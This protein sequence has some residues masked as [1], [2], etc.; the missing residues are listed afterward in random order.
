LPPLPLL[1]PPSLLDSFSVP[2]A[3]AHSQPSPASIKQAKS[4]PKPPTRANTLKS[5]LTK[6]GRKRKA[7]DTVSLSPF[8]AS[9]SSKKKKENKK[10]ER[11]RD[12]L[13]L[14]TP[15]PTMK[16][17][18]LWPLTLRESCCCCHSVGASFSVRRWY[19]VS[20]V[21]LFSHPKATRE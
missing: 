3:V 7:A 15:K 12:G 8:T 10:R 16:K 14:E 6:T 5:Q 19:V 11:D 9:R 4:H 21:W 13:H 20:L 18:L 2:S 17:D 1:L